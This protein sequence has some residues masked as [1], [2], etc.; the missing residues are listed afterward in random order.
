MFVLKN[1][2]FYTIS[3]IIELVSERPGYEQALSGCSGELD[4]LI[5]GAK[6]EYLLGPTINTSVTF[7]LS[8]ETPMKSLFHFDFYQLYFAVVWQ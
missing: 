8:A 2:Y 5:K 1:K 3:T 7:E 4:K 6:K